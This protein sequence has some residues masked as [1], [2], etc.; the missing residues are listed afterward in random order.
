MIAAAL[1]ITGTAA[2]LIWLIPDRTRIT[3]ITAKQ[4]KL[5]SYPWESFQEAQ[6]EP[7]RYIMGGCTEF[8]GGEFDD[9]C[10]F[11]ISADIRS[12]HFIA[13]QRVVVSDFGSYS[14]RWLFADKTLGSNIRYVLVILYKK[15]L[16]EDQIKEAVGQLKLYFCYTLND[17]PK[18]I[19]F[20]VPLESMS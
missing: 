15:D 7:E 13:N 12:N 2:L 6:K 9:Y 11:L 4:S 16:S 1:A 3:D 5:N 8:P 10:S 19:A 14:D 20:T 17:K 18:E